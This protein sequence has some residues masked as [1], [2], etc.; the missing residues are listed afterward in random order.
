MYNPSIGKFLSVDPLTK[1]YPM[2]TPYQF[3]SNTPIAA[4]DLDGLEADVSIMCDNYGNSTKIYTGTE[5]QIYQQAM[6]NVFT[7]LGNPDFQ[8]S[9]QENLKK[10]KNKL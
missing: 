5:A 3:A 9:K 10:Q 1:S 8:F 7:G 6:I 4:V 2:L